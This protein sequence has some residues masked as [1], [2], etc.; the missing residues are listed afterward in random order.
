MTRHTRQEVTSGLA[1]MVGRLPATQSLRIVLVLQHQNQAELENFLKDLYDPSSPSYRQFLTVDQFTEKYGPSREDYEAVKAFARANG[2][3]IKATSRNRMILPVSGS[4][5]NIEKALHVNFGI[6]QHPTEHRT[7]FAPDREPTPDLSVRLWSIGGLDNYSIPKP[8]LVRRDANDPGVRSGATTG[9]CPSKS[10][11][12]SDMRAAYY[13]DGTLTGAGQSLG[14]FEF[15]GTDLVDLTTYFTNVGQTNNVPITLLSVDGQS[16]SCTEKSGCD[17]TEQT[18]DMT[19]AIGMAPG[20]SSLVMYIG[21][22]GLSGQ[23]LD[24]AGILNAMATASPLNAQL[25]ASWLWRPA[26][27]STDEPFFQEFATQGQNFF[28]AAGDN[29]KWATGGFVWPSD[30]GL[31]TSVGGTSLKTTGA[32]GAWA[33]ETGWSDSG[34]GI[35]TDSISIPSWQVATAAGCTKCSQTLRNGPD[36]SAN[37]DF[38][39][40]VCADQ[41]SCTA[42]NYGGTSFATPMWAGFL[43]LVN[44]QAVANGQPT[45]GFVNP[46]LYTLGLSSSYNTDF[47]DI[48]S[49]S[50]GFSATVG[51]DLVTGWGSPTGQALIDA[52]APV[53]AGDFTITAAPTAISVARGSSGKSRIT[54]AVSGGFDSAIALTATGQG[55]G[56]LVAFNPS[57]IAAPGSGVAGMQVKVAPTAKTG[58]RTITITGTGGGNTHTATVTVTIN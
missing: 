3:Q 14:L 20:L 50:N 28:N 36:I 23:T 15:V 9:S 58:T 16:T 27:A 5:E 26:D 22:G 34:G 19:Q 4:V 7:F 44:Q 57:T 48:T 24:D 33:S 56:V 12:G 43:A 52:L 2:L 8:A 30:D 40:Y 54:T 38:S 39:F 10:F 21:K 17:D 47:H 45:L 32:G 25:S 18:L 37:S 41:T 13:T 49:G 35:S 55:A 11:C 31:V 53:N 1:P 46:A 29:G 51:F 6:Y 42:N